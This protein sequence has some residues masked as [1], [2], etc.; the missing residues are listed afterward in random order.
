M[1]FVRG[2]DALMRHSTFWELPDAVVPSKYTVGPVRNPSGDRRI[3]GDAAG[4]V[5]YD[6][7]IDD[8]MSAKQQAFHR[9]R[10]LTASPRSGIGVDGIRYR[11]IVHR[12][13]VWI[14]KPTLHKIFTVL[15]ADDVGLVYREKWWECELGEFGVSDDGF[16]SRCYH[17]HS[18]RIVTGGAGC[19]AFL[20]DVFYFPAAKQY[21]RNR[22]DGES[23]YRSRF[24]Y[25]ATT[26]QER[27]ERRWARLV[28]YGMEPYAALCY[29]FDEKSV[30]EANNARMVFIRVLRSPK[31][32]RRVGVMVSEEL[33]KHGIDSEYLRRRLDE[34]FEFAKEEKAVETYRRG[35]KDLQEC[36]GLTAA[37]KSASGGQG[38]GITGV[39]GGMLLGFRGQGVSGSADGGGVGGGG[40]GLLEDLSRES[41]HRRGLL[42]DGDGGGVSGDS[43]EVEIDGEVGQ[44]DQAGDVSD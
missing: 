38:S 25:H 27:L 36:M 13:G 40:G 12:P 29:L 7:L 17:K 30:R 24:L 8:S 16:V 42:A 44:V 28:A 15:Q 10:F 3:Y 18:K 11:M 43:G 23:E 33:E 14:D 5:K 35:L 34:F 41:E 32:R 26:R 31:V 4:R 6:N 39:G 2:F 1:A 22:V 20:A 37:A 19:V 9:K 21:L